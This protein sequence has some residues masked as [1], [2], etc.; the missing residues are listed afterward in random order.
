MECLAP[1][2]PLFHFASAASSLVRLSPL[3]QF[4]RLRFASVGAPVT[5]LLAGGGSFR[6]W[7]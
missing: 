3:L 7:S 2:L 4:T 6:F 1:A 5:S